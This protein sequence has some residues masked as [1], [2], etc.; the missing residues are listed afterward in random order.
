MKAIQYTQ[1]GSPD[2]LR[3]VEVETPTPKDNEV[4]VKV[5]AAAAN[6]ADWRLMEA[7]P[8][9]VRM[10]DGLTKPK[11]PRL[12]HDF[13]GIVDAVG[14]NITQFNV[15][16]EVFGEV[17]AGAFAEYVC[18]PETDLALK[19]I[20][21]SFEQAA[22]LVMVGL[23]AVQGIRDTGKIQAGQ[24]VLINGASGGIGTFSVQYAK[25]VGAE[26]TGVCSTRNLELVRS[27]GADYVVDYTRDDFTK[28][29]RKYDLV[30]DT[31][32]NRGVFAYARALKPG[33]RAVITG[34][35][36]FPHLIH[37]VAFGGIAARRGGKF[38][39][40]M[41][42][43]QAKQSDLME[44]KDLVER[45]KIKPV[46]DRCYPLTETAEAIRHLETGRAR[47]KVVITVAS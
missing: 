44:I 25:A 14:K 6:P 43:A 2:V 37:V 11:D 45:G 1:Y 27:I 30:F 23:T 19:P 13:A 39:G 22:S 29:G 26:V 8:F 3:L 36:T 10:S 35:T 12:G 20:N 47:G 7:K 46:I 4:L 9:L 28:N 15:G 16:D 42:V 41:G 31:V 24:Q 17:G 32:G 5:M 40:I 18:V 34:F 38:V 33:G 21:A